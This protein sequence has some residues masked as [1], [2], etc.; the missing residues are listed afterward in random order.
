MEILARHLGA[1]RLRLVDVGA[2]DG[3]DPRWDPFAAV[4]DVAAFEPDPTECERLADA[5]RALPYPARFYPHA[6]WREPAGGVP[7]HVANWPVASSIYAPN[8][9]FLRAF[10]GARAL[11]ATREVRTISTTTLDR[12]CAE[13]AVGCDVL[14]LDVEGAE[15]DVLRGGESV[16]AGALALEVEVELNPVFSD[17]PLFADVDAHLRER[18]WALQGLRRTS[19]RRGPA[20][21][22]EASGA[23]GQIVSADALYLGGRVAGELDAIRELKLLVIA[24]AYHQHDLVLARLRSSVVLAE[25][26]SADERV[27][28]ERELAPAGASSQPGDATAWQDDEFF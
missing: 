2:R 11:L 9:E 26:L 1:D 24:S 21:E 5:A 8:D 19:W 16:L 12:A 3:V 17:Q 7:F 18:G 13:H 27:E 15:L 25:L 28:L 14:K 4:I 22:S 6:L 23:G 10:P 20:L